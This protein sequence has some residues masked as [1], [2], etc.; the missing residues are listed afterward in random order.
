M[1]EKIY[2]KVIV[3]FD[4]DLRLSDHPALYHASKQA[5]NILPL[6][7]F[8]QKSLQGDAQRWWLHHSLSALQQS[9]HKKGGKLILRHG[10]PEKVLIELI[11]KHGIAAIYYHHSNEAMMRR[12]QQAISKQL[13]QQAI[14]CHPFNGALLVDPEKLLT[15]QGSYFKVFTPFWKNVCQKMIPRAS[16][17]IAAVDHWLVAASDNLNSWQLLPKKPNWAASFATYWQPGEAGAKRRLKQ[18]I[19][20]KLYHYDK[21]R[22]QLDAEYTSYLSPHLHFGEISPWQ[23]WHAIKQT[24]ARDAALTRH[25]ERFL[26]E[27]GWREFCHYLLYHFPQLAKNNF[28]SAFDHFP[29]QRAGNHLQAW[30]QGKT[31]YPIVDAAMQELWQTG[32]MHNRARMVVASFLTKHLLIDWRKGAAWFCHT[33]LDA[34]LANNSAGWQWVAGCGADAAP[35]FRIFN[36]I[37]QGEKF[38]PKGKYVKCWLPV[39]A[40]LPTAYIHQP[41][42]APATVLNEANIELGQNYPLPIVDHQ[43]ARERALASYQAPKPRPNNR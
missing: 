31:G 12:Q 26:S 29:W 10:D 32:F 1:A 3:W 41:W 6:Y 21:G 24:Q 14:D 37:L 18:F 4:S 20:D 38:D 30:Q 25:C 40:K 28:R 39:L 7:I 9:I 17:P 22:D 15:Q 13:Q 11:D 8:H 36:P 23:I 34:D 35:Y 43:Q 42:Q 27:V 5:N 2:N 16:Y 19:A 33:L